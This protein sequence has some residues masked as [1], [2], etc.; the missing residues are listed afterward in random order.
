MGDRR[1]PPIYMGNLVVGN[2]E[3]CGTDA[4]ADVGKSET[5]GEDGTIRSAGL[6]GSAMVTLFSQGN[7]ALLFFLMKTSPGDVGA[8]SRMAAAPGE[9][10]E[11]VWEPDEFPKIIYPDGYIPCAAKVIGV[12]PE[13]Q[14]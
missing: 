6:C 7:F 10:I 3:N 12:F 14:A 9:S 11:L 13:E 5:I 2:L 1:A 4:A 8:V